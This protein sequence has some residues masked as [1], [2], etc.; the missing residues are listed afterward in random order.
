MKKRNLAALIC[1]GLP[2]LVVWIPGLQQMEFTH[3]VLR[4]IARCLGHYL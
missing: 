1:V 2:A 4:Q 3:F